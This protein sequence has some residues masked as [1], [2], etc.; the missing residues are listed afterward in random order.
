MSNNDPPAHIK[1]LGDDYVFLWQG[2][3][4]FPTREEVSEKIR[5][6]VQRWYSADNFAFAHPPLH[7]DNPQ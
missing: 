7:A 3:T 2:L 6:F 5:L 1:A 4:A